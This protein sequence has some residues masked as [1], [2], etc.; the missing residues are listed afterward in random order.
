MIWRQE[1]C[2]L[3]Q[4]KSNK[5]VDTITALGEAAQLTAAVY[6]RYAERFGEGTSS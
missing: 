5:P 2:A 1:A 3:V 4:R 6:A